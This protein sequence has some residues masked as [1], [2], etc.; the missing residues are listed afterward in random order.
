MSAPERKNN[1]PSR[2]ATGTKTGTERNPDEFRLEPELV[3][4][5]KKIHRADSFQEGV[6]TIAQYYI[7]DLLRLKKGKIRTQSQTAEIRELRD[8]AQALSVKL[9]DF[10]GGDGSKV[11]LEAMLGNRDVP[12]RIFMAVRRLLIEKDCRPQLEA[13]ITWSDEALKKKPK[14]TTRRS[15][16]NLAVELNYLFECHDLEVTASLKGPFCEI[17]TLIMTLHPDVPRGEVPQDKAHHLAKRFLKHLK[18]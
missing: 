8:C 9:D 6:K 15:D 5:L 18:S 13:L 4:I 16:N 10:Y 11:V 17:L 14:K 12:S 3:E 7:H 1:L 2:R